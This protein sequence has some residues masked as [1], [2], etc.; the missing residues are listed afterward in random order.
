MT[1]TPSE[2]KLADDIANEVNS[3]IEHNDV[4]LFMK[5]NELMPQCGYSRT[6]LDLLQ[7]Y[8]DDVE[9]VNV[10]DGH[11]EQYR[12][13]L[14][15]HSD[16]TTIPQAFVEGE[17]IGGADVLSQLDEKGELSDVLGEEANTAPF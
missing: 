1:F 9:I 13:A 12:N 6:A 15:Q 8:C 3:A 17:F 10:L 7:Q 11:V 2:E 5:G 16:W 14:D 4:V